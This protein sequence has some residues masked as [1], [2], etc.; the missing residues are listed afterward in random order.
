MDSTWE[1]HE[2]S[3]SVL[4]VLITSLL[5]RSINSAKH[6]CQHPEEQLLSD[7]SGL[8]FT[9]VRWLSVQSSLLA[10]VTR[11]QKGQETLRQLTCCRE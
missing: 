8:L 6:D 3:D 7:G 10:F 1:K 9:H 5:N 2:P 4:Y 11:Q